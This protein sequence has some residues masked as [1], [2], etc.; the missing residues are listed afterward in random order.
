MSPAK[1]WHRRRNG[2]LRPPAWRAVFL[3]SGLRVLG[4]TGDGHPG[5]TFC[6]GARATRQG[7]LQSP[8]VPFPPLTGTLLCDWPG[9]QQVTRLLPPPTR[10]PLGRRETLEPPLLGARSA[11]S[12][13]GPC[14][15]SLCSCGIAWL[16]FSG[17]G[18]PQLQVLHLTVALDDVAMRS[19]AAW[20]SFPPGPRGSPSSA[21]RPVRPKN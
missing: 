7:P 5:D 8:S 18:E 21:G 9:K 1:V 11:D 20:Q 6:P 16:Q 19:S 14:A 2:R 4:R 10:A 17:K 15:I 12:V 3:N 13:L